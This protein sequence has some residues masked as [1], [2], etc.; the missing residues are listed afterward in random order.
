MC[1][2]LSVMLRPAAKEMNYNFSSRSLNTVGL[3]RHNR[4]MVVKNHQTKE[5]LVQKLRAVLFSS[6]MAHPQGTMVG[7]WPLSVLG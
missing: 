5:I 4:E 1:E 3:C 2:T 7:G 6:Y